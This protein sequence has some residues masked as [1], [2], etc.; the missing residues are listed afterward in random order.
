M[1]DIDA[2]ASQLLEEAKRFLEIA[3]ESADQDRSAACLHAAL[4][5]GFSSL[6]AHVNAICSEF[7]SRPEFST[8]EVA[9][10]LEQEVRLVDGAFK[11]DGLR[12]SRLEDRIAY[13]H[14]RF[15]GNSG[16]KQ[17]NWWSALGGAVKLRNSLTHP[18]GNPNVNVDNVKRAL[19]AIINALD[20]L[21]RTIYK[22]PF[23][24]SVRVLQSKY[25]F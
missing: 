16:F 9:F 18:K 17:T 23:P 15:S 22:K 24:P 1:P 12:M 21:Y 11:R 3:V 14:R 5:L 10:L 7:A 6:E 20:S 13:L 25:S 19:N 4:M 8:H 2:F